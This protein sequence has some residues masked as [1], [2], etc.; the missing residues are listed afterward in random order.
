MTEPTP[1][2]VRIDGEETVLVRAAVLGR[3]DDADIH[4]GD[5]RV[6]R[7]HVRF[8]PTADGWSIEDLASANGTFMNGQRIKDFVVKG[9]ALL[10]LADPNGGVLVE[11]EPVVPEPVV[12]GPAELEAASWRRR[13]DRPGWASTRSAANPRSAISPRLPSPHR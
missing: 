9:P 6:S 13:L 1:L 10:H 12:P 3:A 5:Q 7:K 2:R 11:V 8:I 4:C